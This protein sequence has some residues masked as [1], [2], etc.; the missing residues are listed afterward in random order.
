M[1]FFSGTLRFTNPN[2]E[3]MSY[4]NL[5]FNLDIGTMNDPSNTL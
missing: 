4:S 3:P 2:L 1:I 5:S